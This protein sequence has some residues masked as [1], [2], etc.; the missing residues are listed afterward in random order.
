MG[1]PYWRGAQGVPEMQESVLEHPAE[2]TA[3]G[4]GEGVMPVRRNPAATEVDAYIFIKANLKDLGWDTRNPERVAGGQ[5]WTQNECLSN[6]EIKRLLGLERPENIIKVTESAL[7]VIESKRSHA[8]LERA[9]AEAEE[10]ASKLQK[11]RQFKPLFISGV[12]GNE[13]DTF[14]IRTKFFDGKKFVPV[15]MNDVAITG[16]LSPDNC[17]TILDSQNPNLD[18]PPIDEKFFIARAEHI[19][20]ILHL[21]A[22]NPHQRAAVM[23]ALAARSQWHTTD[24]GL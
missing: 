19:N 13:I 20:E 23:S 15:K 9:L 21:G 6:T 1:S 3:E 10:Y 7:W 14:L 5:V 17:R 22:V 8:E 2:N 11:S 4:K 16:L 24:H 18:N 12:A